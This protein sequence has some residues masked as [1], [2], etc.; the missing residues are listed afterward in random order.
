[1]KPIQPKNIKFEAFN[2]G[3]CDIFIEE[4]DGNIEYKANNLPFSNKTLGYGRYYTAKASNTKVDRVIRIPYLPFSID[5]HHTLCI[6]DMDYF[7][8]LVQEIE[9]SNPRCLQLTLRELQ[10]HGGAI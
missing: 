10:V 9:D 1:M 4:E 2:S 8:E 5:N 3:V 7:I 6:G